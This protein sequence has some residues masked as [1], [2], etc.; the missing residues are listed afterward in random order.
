MSVWGIVRNLKFRELSTLSLIFLKN[1]RYFIPTLKATLETIK[2]CDFKFGDQH[3]FDNPTNAFRHAYWNY[4]ICVKCIQVSGTA[5]EVAAWAKKITDLHEDLSPND[6]L[7][8][9]MDLHN[10][11]I[12]REIFLNNLE[13]ISEPVKF[14]K[15]LLAVAIRVETVEEIK[16]AGSQLV[17]IEN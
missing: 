8:R 2:V 17:Y 1:P 9:E 5:K 13:G 4:D 12:G 15:K 6:A 14:F 3:H 7:A 16:S 10:N 11:K